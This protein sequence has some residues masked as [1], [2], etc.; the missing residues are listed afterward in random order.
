MDVLGGEGL[1]SR[2]WSPPA[3][4]ACC[5]ESGRWP[6]RSPRP[7]T[8]ATRTRRHVD[9]RLHHEIRPGPTTDDS[10][11]ANSPRPRGTRPACSHSFPSCWNG[12]AESRWFDH[13]DL[14][15][16]VERDDLTEPVADAAKGI[17]DG[18]VVLSRRLANRALLRDRSLGL[19]LPPI[20]SPIQHITARRRVSNCSSHR[21]REELINIK[22]YAR[23]SNPMTDVAVALKPSI[24]A[25]L[26]QEADERPSS[27]TPAAHLRA[28]GRERAIEE[29]RGGG[30]RQ[31]ARR[32][33][34][35]A[36]SR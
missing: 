3:T 12:P 30:G 13:R 15:V 4:R 22:A 21:E 6:R 24:D 16:P 20:R 17:L 7:S 11:R 8:S 26:R 34:R 10:P 35:A 25:F 14:H 1:A 2:S 36:A 19:D 18:H 27:P 33:I 31:P 28:G 23:G 32:L 9:G 29:G 5:S